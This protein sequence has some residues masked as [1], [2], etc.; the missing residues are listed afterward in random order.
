MQLPK[1]NFL[2]RNGALAQKRTFCL[3]CQKSAASPS[4]LLFLLCVI[5]PGL[6]ALLFGLL[7][8]TGFSGSFL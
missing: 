5:C 2:L 7:V 1:Q 3:H 8:Y 4:M 6:C